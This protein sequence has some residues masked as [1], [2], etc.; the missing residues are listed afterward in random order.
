M[1]DHMRWEG[2][3]TDQLEQSLLATRTERSRLDAE[4][5]EI[6]EELD[7]RQVAMADGSRSLSEWT[8]ARLDVGLN[9]A[10][11]LVRTMRRTSQRADLR[12][13]PGVR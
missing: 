8:A 5:I 6:L 1:F 4:D 2:I 10:R 13:A 9:T 7:R 3:S 11:D 12:Q